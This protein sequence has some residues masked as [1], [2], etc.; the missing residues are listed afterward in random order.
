MWMKKTYDKLHMA[1]TMMKNLLI[2]MNGFGDLEGYD[3][4]DIFNLIGELEED[5]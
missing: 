1:Y 3:T 5:N 2:E 4:E